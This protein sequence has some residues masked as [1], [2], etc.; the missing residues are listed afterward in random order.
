MPEPHQLA[1]FSVNELLV[2]SLWLDKTSQSVV[3]GESSY[4]AEEAHFY[5]LYLPS[6]YYLVT[7]Q[8]STGR[9]VICLSSPHQTSMALVQ[10]RNLSLLFTWENSFFAEKGGVP[11]LGQRQV[12]LCDRYSFLYNVTSFGLYYPIL[13]VIN[14][15][16]LLC[17]LL[18]SFRWFCKSLEG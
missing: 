4:P 2:Y 6:H 1:P 17:S 10:I 13:L 7:M 11:T 15:N 8:S 18:V 5:C 14:F 12:S 3:K 16:L 9:W